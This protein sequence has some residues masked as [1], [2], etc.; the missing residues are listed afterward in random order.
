VLLR[1]SGEQA[2]I[3]GVRIYDQCLEVYSP[4]VD[5]LETCAV[6]LSQVLTRNYPIFDKRLNRGRGGWR[7]SET[8]QII[9]GP[10]TIK[11][12]FGGKGL[13]S[14]AF[15]MT[16]GD[17]VVIRV[18]SIDSADDL[19]R[20]FQAARRTGATKGTLFTGKVT[21]ETDLIRY[22]RLAETAGSR[23]GGKVTRLT[24]DTFRPDFDE[25][26]DF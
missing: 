22:Q 23:F 16:T 4:R 5:E 3:Q 13:G 2:T 18:T 20:I 14:G 15:L 12:D 11:V 25:L 10:K 8:G 21:S 1:R 6:G 7:D 24:E 9:R 26:P 19:A 17:T